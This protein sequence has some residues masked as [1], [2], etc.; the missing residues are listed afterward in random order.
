MVEELQG[1]FQE[2]E[3]IV[4]EAARGNGGLGVGTVVERLQKQ[5]EQARE[6]VKSFETAV[7]QRVRHAASTADQSIRR[8][9]WESIAVTAAVAF[10]LGVI[11]SRRD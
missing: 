11:L 6:R 5:V 9:P 8:N 10:A 1:L 7:E 4:A 3:A 2:M